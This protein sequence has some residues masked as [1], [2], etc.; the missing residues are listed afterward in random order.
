LRWPGRL[1]WLSQLRVTVVRSEKLV[2][3]AR[4]SSGNL[5]QGKYPPLEATTKQ[6]LLKTK[7][8]SCVL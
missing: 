1:S 2:A 6:W 7:K 8:A 5:E 3:E 4:D